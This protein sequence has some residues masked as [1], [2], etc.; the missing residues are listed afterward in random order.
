MPWTCRTSHY[1][2]FSEGRMVIISPRI[3]TLN[4]SSQLLLLRHGNTDLVVSL[5]WIF[6]LYSS[7]I[8]RTRYCD[9]LIDWSIDRS[10]YLFIYSC[11]QQLTSLLRIKGLVRRWWALPHAALLRLSHRRCTGVTTCGY[12]FTALDAPIVRNLHG[13]A[14]VKSFSCCYC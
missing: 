11:R 5:M 4:S 1:K 3:S 9:W 8:L 13:G 12:C 7:Y 6:K 14:A 2:Q 10:I